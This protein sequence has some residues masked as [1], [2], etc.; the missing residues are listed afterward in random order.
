[1]AGPTTLT[2]V[3]ATF[4]AGDT[5]LLALTPSDYTAPDWSLELHFRAKDGVSIDLSSTDSGGGHL[6]SVDAGTTAQWN[7]ASYSVVGRAVYSDGSKFTFYTGSMRV[8]P[9]LS[10]QAD[11]FDTRTHSKKCLDAIELVMEGKAT[12]DVLNTTIAGQSV[13]R[14][15]PEQLVFWRNY[16]KSEVAAEQ[17]LIDAQNGKA[18][19]NLIRFT[20]TQPT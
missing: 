12:R 11:N 10:Q 1:M 6:F 19:G 13:S 20:F 3:P 5:F 18:Q 17:A 14:L 15:S 2:A 8:L 9:D 16:Y 4:Y 7:A